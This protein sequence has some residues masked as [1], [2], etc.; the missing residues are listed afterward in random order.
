MIDAEVAAE[1]VVRAARGA[2]KQLIADVQV[3]DV[4]QGER[5]GAGRKSI[6]IAV[7]LEP[8]QRT[9]TDADIEAVAAKIVA[10]VGKA[11]GGT[12]RD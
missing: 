4:Y 6:A 3:F 8:R 7:R 5:L 2:D 9:L 1:Q 11:T 12:L 10:Q